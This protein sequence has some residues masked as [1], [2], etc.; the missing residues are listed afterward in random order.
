[1][2]TT[3]PL[4]TST[5]QNV[6]L[7]YSAKHEKFL[8]YM[9]TTIHSRFKILSCSVLLSVFLVGCG[10]ED[11]FALTALDLSNS[12]SD[13][14]SFPADTLPWTD[15]PN[16][17][18][19]KYANVNGSLVGTGPYEAFVIFPAG[20]ANPL[21]SHTQDLPTV[22]LRGTFYAEFDGQRTE[23]PAGSF[24]SLP[25]NMNHYSGC[26]PGEDCMLFQY[27]DDKFDLIT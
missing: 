1:M 20:L 24:F 12:D 22:V 3:T 15:L 4:K 27:Q 21:H 8:H 11:G 13:A 23:Y 25:A 7:S 17:G 16:A 10:G 6:L 18:G 5:R 26:A 19:I 2:V 14:I 9:N